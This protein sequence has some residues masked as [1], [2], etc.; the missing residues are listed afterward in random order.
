[1]IIDTIRQIQL[2]NLMILNAILQRV[3]HVDPRRLFTAFLVLC[4]VIGF[5]APIINGIVITIR[6]RKSKVAFKRECNTELQA[7]YEKV[8]AR[9]IE[10]QELNERVISENIRMAG[11]LGEGFAFEHNHNIRV[12]RELAERKVTGG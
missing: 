4:A 1:M 2:D 8:C 12:R 11:L 10:E 6:T 7:K 3:L 5:F 9:L